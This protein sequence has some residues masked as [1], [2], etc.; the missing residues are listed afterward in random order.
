MTTRKAHNAKPVLANG[1]RYSSLEEAATALYVSKQTLKNYIE[2]K[3]KK[4]VLEGLRIEYVTEA[5]NE[6]KETTKRQA[7]SC[8]LQFQ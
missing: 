6:R 2:G 1:I 3:A 7:R 4:S 8:Q 5:G